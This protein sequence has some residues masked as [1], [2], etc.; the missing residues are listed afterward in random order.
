MR[1]QNVSQKTLK[2]V[3]VRPALAAHTPSPL[4]PRRP[5]LAS[6]QRLLLRS[7]AQC[8]VRYQ[9]SYP[10]RIAIL[11]GGIAGLSSAYFIAREFPK[12]QVVVF[13]AGKDTGGW[14]KSRRVE[15][16][17]S[18][19]KE[20]NVLFELGPRTLRNSTVT[21][22]LVCRTHLHNSGIADAARIDTRPWPR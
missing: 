7:A 17:D 8:A 1:L 20:G 3:A 16:I 18:E 4:Y 13:E 2:T 14:I 10:E 21:A 19:G 12:S 11:G 22:G 15:V 6:S 9:S 5:L